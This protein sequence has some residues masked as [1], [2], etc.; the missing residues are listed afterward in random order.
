MSSLID[1][2][3]YDSKCITNLIEFLTKCLTESPE[4]PHKI[5]AEIYGE[6]SGGTPDR[7]SDGILNF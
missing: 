3:I 5:P 6:A 4:I 1:N 2:D 7:T